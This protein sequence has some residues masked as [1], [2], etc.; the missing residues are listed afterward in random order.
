MG[1]ITTVRRFLVLCGLMFWQGGFTFYA[2]VVVPV[3]TYVL[4]SAEE[5]GWITRLVTPWL[6]LA[7][8]V[9]LLLCAWELWAQ[10][11]ATTVDRWGRWCLWTLAAALLGGLFWL[12][13]WMDQL[14]D[15]E[16]FRLLDRAAF[17]TL[18]RRYLYLSTVQWAAC[19]ILLGWT[20]R[21]WSR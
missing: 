10:P 17:Y 18:H 11:G 16:Q 3:G 6:N 1:P 9:A 2:A 19:L 5:Q 13:P 15:V 8:V 7:G 12:H 20:V 14:L 4:G 21:V